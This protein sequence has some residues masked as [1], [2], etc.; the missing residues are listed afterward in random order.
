[1]FV[2]ENKF[3]YADR[4]KRV[5]VK[6]TVIDC[7]HFPKI[8]AQREDTG[9]VFECREGYYRLDEYD[10]ACIDAQ[11]KTERNGDKKVIKKVV[12]TESQ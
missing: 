2:K 3:Y 11:I 6:C 8:I 1:M 9:A 7:S 12:M 4:G 10:I 5:P